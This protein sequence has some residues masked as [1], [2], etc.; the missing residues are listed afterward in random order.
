MKTLE[1]KD[2]SLVHAMIALVSRLSNSANALVLL[3][4]VQ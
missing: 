4:F 2:L 3:T 1:N